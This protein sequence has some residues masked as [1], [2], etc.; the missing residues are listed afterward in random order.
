MSELT[1]NWKVNDQLT[2]SPKVNYTH[3]KPWYSKSIHNHYDITTSRILGELSASYDIN[4]DINIL[5]GAGYYGD[6]GKT[7]IEGET[8]FNK[9]DEFTYNNIY[10]YAQGLIKTEYVNIIFGGRFDKHSEIDA[11]FSP[12][13]ALT[14]VIDKFHYK[15]LYSQAFRS[16]G[17]ENMNASHKYINDTT[18]SPNAPN[19]LP[20][21]T[22]VIELELG[23]QLTQNFSATV[24]VFNTIIKDPII[25]FF[26]V[27]ADGNDIEGYYNASQSG[28]RGAELDLRYK[29]NWGYANLSYTFYTA[30]SINEVEAYEVPGNKDA[31]LAFPQHKIVL[32]ASYNIMKDLSINPTLNIGSKRYSFRTS[33]DEGT[34]IISEDKSAVLLNLFLNYR[35]FLTPG[36]NLG[37][38]V[39]DLIG[40][41]D[42]YIQP[43]NGSHSPF[44]GPSREFVFKLSYGL[45]LN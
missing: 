25:Y 2:I 40:N 43:Y 23:Y 39:F 11:A 12:R 42:E 10:A 21:K 45:N 28:T 22:S 33:D 32:N 30:N 15:L 9:K 7:N 31:M 26:Y 20:E 34:P 6:K 38:G 18:Y 24:N 44:P 19:I 5:A 8:F 4:K 13:I 1:Y 14:K 29:D 36:L 16:Q 27:D 41:N 17:V 3:Q 37:V 35:N